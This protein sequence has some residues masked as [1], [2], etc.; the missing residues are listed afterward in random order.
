MKTM[1]L[2]LTALTFAAGM[3]GAGTF[4][5]NDRPYDVARITQ[6]ETIEVRADSVM[7]A[8]ELSR[9]SIDADTIITVTTFPTKTTPA[10]NNR[11]R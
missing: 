8:A 10:R 4:S 7:N 9:A 6:V 1:I 11:D 5:R 2:A 3:S